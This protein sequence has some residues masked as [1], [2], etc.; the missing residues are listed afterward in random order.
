MVRSGSSYSRDGVEAAR[1][2]LLEL[3]R[4][5]G[6]YRQAMAVVGGWVPDLLLPPGSPPYLGT[7]DVDLALDH[8]AFDEAGYKTIY[9]LLR[10]LDYQP[11]GQP[12]IFFRSMEINGREIK[13]EVDFLAGEY[14]GAGRTRRHQKIQDLRPR[15][16]RGCDLV[17]QKDLWVEKSLQGRLPC[18]VEDRATIRVASL[19]PFLVMK[20]MALH[21]RI[22]AKDAYD[23]YYCLLNF[24]GGIEALAQDF[25]A[26]RD[27]RLVKEGLK[28]I[29]GKFSSIRAFGPAKAAEV[30][31][32]TELDPEAGEIRIRDAYERVS[33]FLARMG[34]ITEGKE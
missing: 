32:T 12:F 16:A 8:Q 6:E 15:K 18:G 23:I 11:G 13:V 1:A 28:K 3:A 25:L 9:E 7:L 20:G 29:A 22:K 4:G 2:V 26:H 19:V 14:G 24:P 33:A 34:I 10:E 17:F 5:L 21:D 31:Q 30:Y 27:H